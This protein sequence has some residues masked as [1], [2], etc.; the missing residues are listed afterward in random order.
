[1][2]RRRGQIPVGVSLLLQCTAA[3]APPETRRRTER[4][5]Y[6]SGVSIAGATACS[7][8]HSMVVPIDVIK[9]RMQTDPG[10]GP[11]SA[12]SSVLRSAPQRGILRGGAFCA[13]LAPTAV[14]YWWQGAA[15]FGGY[16]LFKQNSF[17]RLR[18]AGGDDAVKRWRLPVS[19]ASAAAAEICATTLLAPM[20]VLK[21]RMQTDALSAA[22]GALATCSHIARHEGLGAFYVGLGPIAMRQVPYT[23]TK[24]VAYETISRAMVNVARRVEQTVWPSSRD[25]RLRPYAVVCSGLL[26]GAAAAVVS[27]P[28]DLLL[29]RL[30]GAATA[31]VTTNVAEC[32]IAQGCAEQASYLM[33]LGL[34]G[35][36]AGLKP[37]LL[38]TAAMTSVQFS[39]YENVRQLLGVAGSLPV[40]ASV[41]MPS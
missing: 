24:L 18:S 13:G 39:L 15:K 26:A 38:M 32:V 12:A 21:L 35:A 5:R 1:M 36:F 25:D 17:N 16:E 8:S 9:T 34:R 37:R 7:I 33:S 40:Q 29:T 20:E 3:S 28:A 4:L 22:R 6:F 19:L 30:C 10:L 23:V 2:V 31:A 14:G 41:V 27:H 11:V